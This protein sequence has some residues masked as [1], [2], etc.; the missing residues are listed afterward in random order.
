MITTRPLFLRFL[1]ILSAC[2][3]GVVP[4]AVAGPA[5][6]EPIKGVVPAGG[7]V[8]DTTSRIESLSF[9]NTVFLASEGAQNRIQWTGSYGACTPGTTAAL[10]QEDVRRRVNYY[11]AICSLPICMSI[12]FRG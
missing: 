6:W 1:L 8:V 5:T 11:R 9:Y 7:F 4:Q 10:F 2:C 3:G 12:P